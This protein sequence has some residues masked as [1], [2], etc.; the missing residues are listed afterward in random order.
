MRLVVHRGGLAIVLT[1]VLALILTIFPVPGWAEELRPH[2][3]AL[4]VIYWAMALPH[5]VSI[6]IAWTMGLFLD[7]LFDALLG[8]HALALAL[9]AFFTIRLHQRLRV[10]PLWQQAI[11]IFVLCLIYSMI[12]L[13]IKGLTGTAPNLWLFIL[14]SLTSAMIWPLVFLFLRQVRRAYRVS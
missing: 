14:P 2:M 1:F 10:F 5:R 6:G 12:V 11:V 3:L 4:T 13:W 9:I 8:Q 7:V